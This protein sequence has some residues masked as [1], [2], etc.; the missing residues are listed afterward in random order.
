MV[1]LKKLKSVPGTQGGGG[2]AAENRTAA[3]SAET[4]TNGGGGGGGAS[5]GSGVAGSKEPGALNTDIFKHFDKAGRSELYV[6][7]TAQTPIQLQLLIYTHAHTR[8]SQHSG[9]RQFVS[10]GYSR[11]LV[12]PVWASAAH[13]ALS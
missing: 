2:D 12:S 11:A 5:S 1:R 10:C 8:A 6:V 7:S 13:P 9:C 3:A 4:D